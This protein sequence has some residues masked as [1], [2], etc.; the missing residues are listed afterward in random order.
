MRVAVAGGTG[1]VGRLVV[2][3]LMKTGHDPVVLA[4]SQGVDLTTGLGLDEKLAG[5]E[6]LIDVSNVITVRK[7]VSVTFF[8]AATAQLLRAGAQAGVGHHVALSIVGVDTVDYGYYL[9]KRRQEQLVAAG[10][11][12]WS[13]LRTTQFHEF[14]QQLLDRAPGPLALVPRMRVR[15]VAATEVAAALVDRA[16]GR[17]SGFVPPMA[18]PEQLELADMAR[19]LL[20]AR[21]SRRLLV[22]IRLPG[23][24]GAAMAG[25]ALLPE[26]PYVRGHLT[27]AQYLANLSVTAGS[28]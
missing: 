22:P 16:T 21:S 2:Q 3:E 5:C 23:R 11:V 27:F 1:L 7:S 17:P 28:R 26:D 9:G 4:R 19:R 10:P 8:S 18:G 24:A 14:A 25:G 15:P 6:A 20:E 12:P 13:V